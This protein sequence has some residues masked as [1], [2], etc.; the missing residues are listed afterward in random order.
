MLSTENYKFEFFSDVFDK[1]SFGGEMTEEK[2]NLKINQESGQ[3]LETEN[4]VQT[5]LQRNFA[6]KQ[7]NEKHLWKWEYLKMCGARIFFL[8]ILEK[9]QHVCML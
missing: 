7:S 3:R 5:I 4:T 1:K 6:T 8:F 9:I 2:T